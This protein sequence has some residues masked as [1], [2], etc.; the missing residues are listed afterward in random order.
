MKHRGRKFTA[1]SLRELS[2][3]F[4]ELSPE[5]Y[6]MFESLGREATEAHRCGA[7]TFPAMSRTS[8]FSR[9]GSALPT[10]PA[11]SMESLQQQA[12]VAWAA[13]VSGQ[14]LVPKTTVAKRTVQYAWVREMS[15]VLRRL[16][17]G[18]CK[19]IQDKALDLLRECK[20]VEK[21][22]FAGREGLKELPCTSFIG[23]PGR[24][25]GL[26]LSLDTAVA[27]RSIMSHHS[28]ISLAEA[29]QQ[30]HL[31]LVSSSWQHPLRRQNP[32]RCFKQGYCSC[33]GVGR[34]LLRMSKRLERYLKQKSINES[35]LHSLIEGHIIL[36]WLG[37][38]EAVKSAKR[39]KVNKGPA[40]SSEVVTRYTHVSLYYQRPW[41]P[42]LVRL[43]KLAEQREEEVKAFQ[44]RGRPP[45]VL[46]RC[47]IVGTVDRAGSRHGMECAG[48]APLVAKNT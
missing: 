27:A 41:R 43:N 33:R 25:P 38:R 40:E 45:R 22:C 3:S 17:Q 24:C 18:Q 1:E 7:G 29:W 6:A 48:L 8:Q 34:L 4:R 30:R 2:R 26:A 12:D 23:V 14:P 32:R 37:D 44:C 31:G 21:T 35:F 47:D 39:R 10:G 5:A 36:E 28:H 16:K 11:E 13:A 19:D 20:D 46:G 15:R 42:T 9:T